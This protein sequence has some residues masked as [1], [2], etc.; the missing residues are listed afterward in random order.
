MLFLWRQQ[1][2]ETETADVSNNCEGI[3]EPVSR[4]GQ[5]AVKDAAAGT[6]TV[7]EIQKTSEDCGGEDKTQEE[8]AALRKELRAR[9]KASM[10][11][12]FMSLLKA[13]DFLWN[14]VNI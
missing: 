4:D 1:T 13:F 2:S 5:S 6:P 11:R 8:L 3:A 14:V 7:A 12:Q 9:Q 10:V